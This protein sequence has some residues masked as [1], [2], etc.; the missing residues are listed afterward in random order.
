M[1]PFCGQ[2]A[3]SCH[4][5]RVRVHLSI[6]S[7]QLDLRWRLRQRHRL[8]SCGLLLIASLFITGA[9]HAGSGLIVRFEATGQHAVLESAEHIFKSGRSFSAH[10]AD[11]SDSLDRLH[12][13]L[14][15]HRVRAL[16]RDGG[17]DTLAAQRA[18]L[19]ARFAKGSSAS[20]A[21]SRPSWRRPTSAVGRSPPSTLRPSTSAPCC[22]PLPNAVR[23]GLFMFG[24]VEQMN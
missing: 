7:L 14:G 23:S 22:C 10:T 3:S 11:G 15:V 4:T 5:H 18:R 16:F 8:L 6:P 20:R 1:D 9:G 13:D 17:P 19:R 21:P 12:R 2:T 24:A